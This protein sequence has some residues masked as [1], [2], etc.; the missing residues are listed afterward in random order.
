VP[1]LFIYLKLKYLAQNKRR[2]TTRDI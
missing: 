2:S 1:K